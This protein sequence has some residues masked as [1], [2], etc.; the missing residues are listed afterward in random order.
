MYVW[1]GKKLCVLVL[2]C[3]ASVVLQRLFMSQLDFSSFAGS[4]SP[5]AR[6]GHPSVFIATAQLSF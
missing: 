1:L 6:E 3:V 2:L 5:S 4:R